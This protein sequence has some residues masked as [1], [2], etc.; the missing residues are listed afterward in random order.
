MS[1][2]ASIN[3]GEHRLTLIRDLTIACPL[4]VMLSAAQRPIWEPL[5][6]P[7]D[8]DGRVPLPVN[9]LLIEAGERKILIDAGD[10]FRPERSAEKNGHLVEHLAA[11]GT[12]PE[13]IDTV[14]FTHLHTDHVLGAARPT[15]ADLEPVFTAATH[16]VSTPEAERMAD[17]SRRLR[18]DAHMRPFD[19]QAATTYDLLDRA[20]LLGKIEPGEPIAP[21]VTPLHIPGHAPGQCSLLIEDGQDA[22]LY[23]ADAFHWEFEFEHIELYGDADPEPEK[24]PTSRHQMIALAQD[25][26]AILAASHLPGFARLRTDGAGR[27]VGLSVLA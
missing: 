24:V 26:G 4:R 21:G 23:L 18:P 9:C 19:E 12:A 25:R 13:E 11:L 10:G 1:A 3:V 22:L 7:T 5:A 27:P 15:D 8:D 20:G 2:V 16:L 14:F 6:G 17:P